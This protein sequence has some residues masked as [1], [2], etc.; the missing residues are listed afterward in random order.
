[1]YQLQKC[2][3]EIMGFVIE[4]GI[5]YTYLEGMMRRGFSVTN[6]AALYA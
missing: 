4:F 5:W 3:R 1:M 2:A 6:W